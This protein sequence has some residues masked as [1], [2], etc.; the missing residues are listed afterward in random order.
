[1]ARYRKRTALPRAEG[2]NLA[3]HEWKRGD[4]LKR[5]TLGVEEPLVEAEIFLP[6]IILVPLLAFDGDGYRLGYG[7]G[8]FDRTMRAL[9]ETAHPPQFIGVA[10]GLQEVEQVPI[11][12]GDEKLDGILTEF[13]VSM[14]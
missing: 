6:E 10:Y 13:G 8:Y 3:F 7:G 11:D 4:A 9:R 5:N 2:Q 1:M 12:D 14:F